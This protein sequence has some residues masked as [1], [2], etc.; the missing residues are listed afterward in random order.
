MALVQEVG[1][2]SSSLDQKRN[3]RNPIGA[4]YR[5]HDEGALDGP[6]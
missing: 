2:Q 6:Y 5:L 1:E 3:N 4:F